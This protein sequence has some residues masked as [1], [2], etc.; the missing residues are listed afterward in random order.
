MG[1]RISLTCTETPGIS[2]C[3]TLPGIRIA[4][5]RA[6]VAHGWR[7]GELTRLIRRLATEQQHAWNFREKVFS[8]PRR[9][10]VVGGWCSRD[11]LVQHAQSI[12]GGIDREAASLIMSPSFPL[13]HTPTTFAYVD[14]EGWEIIN[15]DEIPDWQLKRT[16]ALAGFKRP[17]AETAIALGEYYRKSGS[18]QHPIG[19]T[20]HVPTAWIR[21]GRE[22]KRLIFHDIDHESEPKLCWART[23]LCGTLACSNK[24]IICFPV[25]NDSTQRA[26]E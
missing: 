2:H 5:E 15:E 13:L 7:K 14:V 4:D 22:R 18:R 16:L 21:V 9:T 20:Y 19:Y 26:T 24:V 1:L 25:D 10:V 6:L 11:K 3:L 23:E 12:G 17:P 8:L